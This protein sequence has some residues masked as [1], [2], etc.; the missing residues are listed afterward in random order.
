[1]KRMNPLKLFTFLLFSSLV[2]SACKST[3]DGVE[4]SRREYDYVPPVLIA[5]PVPTPI[6]TPVPV[7]EEPEEVDDNADDQAGAEENEEAGPKKKGFFGRLFSREKPEAKEAVT[8]TRVGDS[9]EMVRNEDGELVV[10]DQ[11]TDN[12]YRLKVGDAVYISLS[13]SGGLDEEIQTMIDDEGAIKLRYIGTVKGKGLSSTELEREIE[14]E[15]TDR[16]KIYKDVTVRVVVPNTFYSIGGEVNQPG[17]FPLVGRVTLSH[18]I[19]AA[20]NFTEWVDEKEITLVRNNEK[21]VI[22]FKKIRNNPNLD[23]ELLAGDVVWVGRST[24]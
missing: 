13:G 6:P 10:K 21:V 16:Q 1:M 7:V 9:P 14:A 12:V 15:Y 8:V 11:P 3:P 5:T 19:V 20:G 17:R 23:V 24:F 22:N 2:F 4:R 18:A